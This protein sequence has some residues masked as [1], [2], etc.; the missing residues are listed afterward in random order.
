MRSPPAKGPPAREQKLS[1][2]PQDIET[3]VKLRHLMVLLVAGIAILALLSLAL[4]WYWKRNQPVF[5]DAPK[6]VAALQAFSRD[7]FIHGMRLPSTVSLSEL[8]A[9]GYLS[10][11][12]V[13]AFEGIEVTFSNVTNSQ[14]P[15]EIMVRARLPDGS[16]LTLMED[17][18]VQTLGK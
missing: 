12:D 17:G 5:N 10:T 14:N 6:L 8:V 2:P 15:R 4:E 3:P 13:H 9:G 7:R 16:V 1:A 18:T 11:N